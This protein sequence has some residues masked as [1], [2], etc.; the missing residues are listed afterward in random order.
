MAS[1]LYRMY[2]Q[3]SNDFVIYSSVSKK[4]IRLQGKRGG[5]FK[6]GKKDKIKRQES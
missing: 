3:A 6:R 1:A 4:D 5:R 2:R